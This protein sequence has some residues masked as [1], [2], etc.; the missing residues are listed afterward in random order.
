MPILMLVLVLLTGC[1]PGDSLERISGPTMGSS[2]TV[3]YVRTPQGPAPQQVQREVQGI[4]AGIDQRFSTYR[5][6]SLVET[7]NRLPANRCQR[8]PADVLEL[9]GVGQRLSAQ[10][11]GAFDLTV[12]P[13]LDLWG[14]G[15]QS[16]GEQVPT[17]AQL[18]HARQRVGY[19]QLRI[20]GEQLCKQAA[21]EIDFNSIAAGHAV[22]LIGERLQA[23]GITSFLVEAT[24]ELKAVGHKPD[25]SAWQ[26]ALELPRDDQQI[27]SEVI[28][29]D[30]FGVS[31][32]GDYRNYFEQNGRRYSHTFDARL[33]R[34]VSHELAAV[35]V[36]APSALMADGYSTVLLILGPEQGWA[37]AVAHHLAAVFVTRSGQ[38]F[39]SQATPAF[40]QHWP[41][42][43]RASKVKC[44]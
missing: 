1:K 2:Y 42:S 17:V 28:A 16:R 14:F 35:T 41:Q 20:D 11:N 21:V 4:L 8:M 3:Q 19:H 5:S 10:S 18:E 9:V 34:P 31:T 7:F 6:D 12:E 38:G 32:S 44:M 15:P 40:C 26:I 30:G 27:A 39:V 33:G 23:L 29:V 24:G 43:G 25:G 36:L 37:L 22:D 13:L